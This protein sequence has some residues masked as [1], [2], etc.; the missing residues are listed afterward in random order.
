MRFM[1]SLTA[2]RIFAGLITVINAV[3]LFVAKGPS[4]MDFALGVATGLGV[5]LLAVLWAGD[6]SGRGEV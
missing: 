6:F 5:G 3:S 1:S 4:W 2:A